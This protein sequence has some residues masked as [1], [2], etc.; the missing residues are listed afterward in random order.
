MKLTPE[1]FNSLA[2]VVASI[3]AK[4]EDKESIC[5]IKEFLLQVISN[6][7]IYIK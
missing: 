4:G 7:T 3:L 5:K 2:V 6:L 1:E